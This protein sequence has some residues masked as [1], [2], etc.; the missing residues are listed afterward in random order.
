MNGKKLVSAV[1]PVFNEEKYILKCISS[2]LT[3]DYGKDSIEFIFVDGGSTDKTIK[4]IE[5]AIVELS[6]NGKVLDNP[7]RTAPAAMNIGI[8]VAEG[9]IIIR[10]DAHSTYPEDYISKCVKYLEST[11]AANVGGHWNVHGEGFVGECIAAVQTSKF[12]VGATPYRV[13]KETKWVES[14]PFGAFHKKLFD[15]IGLFNVELP[16]SED[17]ELNYRIRK[18]GR[19]V[20]LAGDIYIDYYCRRTVKAFSKMA[21]SNGK[22]VGFTRKRYPGVMGVRY[23]IPFAF[24]ISIILMLLAIVFSIKTAAPIF[25]LE[26]VAYFSLDIMSAISSKLSIAQKLFLIV[27]FPIYHISYGLGTIMGY[28]LKKM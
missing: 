13:N 28:F 23:L 22:G 12:G 4:L 11:D 8:P 6:F 19:R 20:L 26:F 15:E 16:R 10:F 14:V 9:D 3:Q 21:F 5:E 2:L 1:I 27:L 18:S 7:G 17:N 25:I 24:V